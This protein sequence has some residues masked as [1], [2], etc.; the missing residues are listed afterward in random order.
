[1]HTIQTRKSDYFISSTIRQNVMQR[2]ICLNQFISH[3]YLTDSLL[4]SG[5]AWWHH[6]FSNK[7]YYYMTSKVQKK[8]NNQR[9]STKQ[10][11]PFPP[12]SFKSKD[13]LERD[14]IMHLINAEE[15]RPRTMTQFFYLKF[16]Q[17]RKALNCSKT[18]TTNFRNWLKRQI[19]KI[20]R[21]QGEEILVIGEIFKIKHSNG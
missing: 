2:S 4:A 3:T 8:K 16:I 13:Y 10:A 18:A 7:R 9:N 20:K 1:M 12:S 21:G 11:F 17:M 15:N 6:M 19:L 14:V 5:T